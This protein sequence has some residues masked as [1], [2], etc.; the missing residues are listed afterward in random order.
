[1]QR[2]VVS[3]LIRQAVLDKEIRKL[4]HLGGLS[5]MAEETVV[6]EQEEGEVVHVQVF[7]DAVDDDVGDV[8]IEEKLNEIE[9][10]AREKGFSAGLEMGRQE[11]YQQLKELSDTAKDIIDSLLGQQEKFLENTRQHMVAAVQAAVFKIVGE[12]A[13]EVAENTF[14]KVVRKESAERLISICLN[15]RDYET[16]SKKTAFSKLHKYMTLDHRVKAGGCIIETLNG[17]MDARLETQLE[18][19]TSLLRDYVESQA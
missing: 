17:G 15:T 14:N 12:H 6:R 5:A 11:A 18:E 13:S 4:N 7:N 8:S 2:Q 16:L 3:K 1:M 19:F 9:R 10:E